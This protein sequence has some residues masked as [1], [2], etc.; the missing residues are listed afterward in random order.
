M[1]ENMKI[2]IKTVSPEEKGLGQPGQPYHN[3]PSPHGVDI[4]DH[5]PNTG[6]EL[7][8]KIALEA[9]LVAMEKQFLEYDKAASEFGNYVVIDSSIELYDFL[10]A[11]RAMLEEQIGLKFQSPFITEQI[12]LEGE[13]W[14][15]QERKAK[16][17]RLVEGHE[18]TKQEM[19][20]LEH[21]TDNES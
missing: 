19:E 1:N 5:H 14:Q 13:H 8:P 15:E 10:K 6:E 2:E 17:K 16:R 7:D 3:M 11:L 20:R 21:G 4:K 18:L 12:K 9:S